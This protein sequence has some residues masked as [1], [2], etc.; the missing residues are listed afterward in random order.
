M[1][2][3]LGKQVGASERVAVL[4][5]DVENNDSVEDFIKQVNSSY[6]QQIY[7]LINNAGIYPSGWNEE[8][9]NSV[10]KTN[11]DGPVR[12]CQ[13]IR[14]ALIEGNQP[15]FTCCIL[16]RACHRHIGIRKHLQKW[17]SELLEYSLTRDVNSEFTCKVVSN[18]CLF[19]Y[20]V[21]SAWTESAIQLS[22]DFTKQSTHPHLYWLPVSLMVL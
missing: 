11:F 10:K 13:A 4:Q 17:W 8:L 12:L 6:S 3:I 5:L 18:N 1:A 19:L 15:P 2:S 7:A 20:C 21:S 14:P 9:F 22:S 16:C